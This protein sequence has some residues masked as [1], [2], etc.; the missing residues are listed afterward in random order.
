MPLGKV[1]MSEKWSTSLRA[2]G[3]PSSETARAYIFVTLGCPLNIYS[4]ISLMPRSISTASKPTTEAGTRILQPQSPITAPVITLTC[5]G[6]IKPSIITP[7]LSEG[8]HHQG[9]HFMDGIDEEIFQLSSFSELQ[10][11]SN[12]RSCCFKRLEKQRHCLDF[13]RLSLLHQG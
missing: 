5:P 8:P 12:G 6:R 13:L 2:S 7:G 10:G 11:S 3:L 1:P 4:I 9:D